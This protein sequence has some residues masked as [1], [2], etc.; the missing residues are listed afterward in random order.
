MRN[1]IIDGEGISIQADLIENKMS[2]F[3]DEQEKSYNWSE[4]GRN[5]TYIAQ[6][7]ALVES[8]FTDICSFSEG[9]KTMKLIDHIKSNSL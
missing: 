4:I 7:K 3:M 8:N 9:M 1:I 5:Y 2:V 6:H